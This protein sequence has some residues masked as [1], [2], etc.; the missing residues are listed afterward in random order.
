MG[1]GVAPSSSIPLQITNADNT[2]FN[3][4]LNNTGGNGR[5]LRLNTGGTGSNIP[6]LSVETAGTPVLT[7][8]NGGSSG[9]L[10]V[11]TADN[12]NFAAII[13]NGPA[14]TGRVL[15]LTSGTVTA[16]IPILQVDN[17]SGTVFGVYGDGN[18]GVGDTTPASLFTVG[19]GDSFTAVKGKAESSKN[20][21]LIKKYWSPFAGA[22]FEQYHWIEYIIIASVFVLGTSSIL[23][24]YKYHHQNKIPAFIF[25]GGLIFLMSASLLKIVFEI[26]SSSG[27]LLSGIGGI[28]AGIGQLYN[29]RLSSK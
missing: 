5:V 9:I 16:N 29:L 12:T 13:N 17:N 14:G 27:H 4:Y 22:Y 23:H 18:V 19:S 11:T 1:I 7:V 2:N 26:N 15:K 20:K 28:A 25:F 8:N 10:N 24:G 6:I 21:E 3:T